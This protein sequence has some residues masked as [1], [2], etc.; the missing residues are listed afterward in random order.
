MLSVNNQTKKK[1]PQVP[2]SDIANAV[3]GPKYDL[4]LVFVGD[5]RSKRLNAEYRSRDK[6]ANILSFPYEKDQGEIF[7]N[8]GRTEREAKKFSHTYRQHLIFLFIHGCLHLKGFDHS[9][10][11]ENEEQ[12]FF[13]RFSN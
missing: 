7:I 6:V 8:L 11:M 10:K 5:T 12:R 1:A 4:G 9:V 3:L 13:E 2:F